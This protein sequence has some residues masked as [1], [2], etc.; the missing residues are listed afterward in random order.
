MRP[1]IALFSLFT[2]FTAIQAIALDLDDYRLVDLSH[3]YDDSTLF[4]PT[5]P[6]HFE[7]QTLAEGVGDGGWFY[8]AYS[9]CTPEHGGTHLDA[10]RHFDAAG[11]TAEAIPL[12]R[13]ITRAVVIDVRAQAD[14]DRD[15][16]L[17][18]A[19]VEAF[20][21]DHGRIPAGSTVLM[22]S[23]WSERW[24]DALAYLGDDT[25]GDA[26]KLHFPGFGVAASRLLVEQRQVAA[27]GVDTASIDHGQSHDF[28]VHRVAAAHNVLGL[29]NLAGLEALP[30]TGA[31]LLALPMKIGGG[32]GGPA[33][34][35]ALV[36]H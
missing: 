26:S 2:L 1:I 14:R 17:S 30:A 15:Y 24:P 23:G 7:K 20:E 34:V 25:P 18:V 28:Q 22:R 5:S 29:E 36:P 11:Q 16:R 19:D 31:L 32:S 8:S 10:P 3:T 27:L 13:L 4:W 35:V 33:R 6:T 12:D 21:R 9:V